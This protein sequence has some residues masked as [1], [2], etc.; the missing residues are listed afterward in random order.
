[1]LE[2]LVVGTGRCGTAYMAH[3]LTSAGIPCGHESIFNTKN[4][5]I[6]KIKEQIKN[7]KDVELSECSINDQEPWVDPSTIVADSSYLSA[8]FIKDK[9]FYNTKII[10][11]VRHPLDVI[12]SFVLDGNY[13]SNNFPENTITYQ[14]YIR[15]YVPK[16]Y[17]NNHNPE[18][19]AALYYIYWNHLIENN[20]QSKNYILHN[21]ENNLKKVLN[22]IGKK[23]YNKNLSRKINTWNKNNRKR[24]SLKLIDKKILKELKIIS[25]KYK[26][27]FVNM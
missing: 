1:M 3:L 10:H 13:F 14:K 16:V 23:Q 21:I 5:T 11:V 17:K 19:R 4:S 22:F 24:I 26:Y 12:S 15:K 9:I 2:Y 25:E 7:K 18:T 27:H 20:I 6:K 8:P